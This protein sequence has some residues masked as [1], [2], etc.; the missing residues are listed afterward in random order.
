[1]EQ[2]QIT[3]GYLTEAF[4]KRTKRWFKLFTVVG[5]TNAQDAIKFVLT[6]G[7]CFGKD[8]DARWVLTAKRVDL[9]PPPTPE[10]LLAAG[11]LPR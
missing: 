9:V 1:M 11:A 2:P 10:E 4:N 5:V 8:W 7:F 3:Y 6:L